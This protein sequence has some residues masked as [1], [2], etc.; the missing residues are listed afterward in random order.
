MAGKKPRTVLNRDKWAALIGI[1]DAVALGQRTARKPD[2]SKRLVECGLVEQDAGGRLIV[3]PWGKKF[4]QSRTPH[5]DGVYTRR[6]GLRRRYG[7]SV[8][9]G[10]GEQ[11]AWW[12]AN[13]WYNDELKG[14]PSGNLTGPLRATEEDAVAK[15]KASIENLID[16]RE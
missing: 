13:V 5:T 2:I 8:T 15:V 9:W 4:L 14:T 3:T 11:S 6:N 16:V 1:N 7:Y 10:E 12:A